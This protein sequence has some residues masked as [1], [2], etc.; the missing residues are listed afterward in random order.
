MFIT[1]KS[2]LQQPFK[3]IYI[4]NFYKVVTHY[5]VWCVQHPSVSP[6]LFLGCS[7]NALYLTIQPFKDTSPLPPHSL[8]FTLKATS[9]FSISY[10]FFE[11]YY[12]PL[13]MS[14]SERCHEEQ[15]SHCSTVHL[16]ELT[17]V[18]MGNVRGEGLTLA[19]LNGR[20]VLLTWFTDVLIGLQGGLILHFI[21]FRSSITC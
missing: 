11:E 16:F 10:H 5:W 14:A 15:L 7:N 18:Y 19:G 6:P 3:V 8:S 1:L 21:V 17:C 20:G 13:L 2:T 12:T 9:L 4:Y